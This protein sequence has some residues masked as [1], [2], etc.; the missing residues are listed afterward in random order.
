MTVYKL[1]LIALG[2]FYPA[3]FVLLVRFF[4]F[5][6]WQLGAA[7]PLPPLPETTAHTAVSADWLTYRPRWS[8]QQGREHGVNCLNMT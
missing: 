7:R 4:P 2:T 6:V 5:A 1:H 3:E 8:T